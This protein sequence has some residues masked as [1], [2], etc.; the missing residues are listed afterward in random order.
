MLFLAGVEGRYIHYFQFPHVQKTLSWC[1]SVSLLFLL[2]K[3]MG[4][5]STLFLFCL[6]EDLAD[7][8]EGSTA[9]GEGCVFICLEFQFDNM[10]CN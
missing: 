3:E 2:R 4:G 10:N 7:M 6:V 1:S 8:V 5:Y 9:C